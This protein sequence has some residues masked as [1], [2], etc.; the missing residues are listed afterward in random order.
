MKRDPNPDLRQRA[1]ILYR[2]FVTSGDPFDES[3]SEELWNSPALRTYFIGEH[4]RDLARSMGVPV[5]TAPSEAEMYAAV[6]CREGIATTVV[7]SDSDALLYGSPHVTRQLQLSRQSICRATLGDLEA[8]VG[9]DLEGLRDLAIVCGCDFHREGVKGIGPRRGAMM[10]ERFGSLD[11]LL[12]S[13]GYSHSERE[14]FILARQAFDE[15]NYV[16]PVDLNPTLDPPII[17]KFVSLLG[18]IMS[19]ERAGILAQRQVNLWRNF[20]IRQETLE[21]W[22]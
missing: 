1:Q 16:S 20:R 22:L 15:V 17:S 13:R 4:V 6:L 2:Q 5:L 8:N 11:A 10:L 18:A 3:I 19:E 21:Q 12:K 14:Y 9:L 7:S